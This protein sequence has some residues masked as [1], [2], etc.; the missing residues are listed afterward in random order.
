VLTR[1]PD[2][3]LAVPAEDLPWRNSNFITGVESMPVCFTPTEKVGV[4]A[5]TE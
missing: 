3:E 5:A 1:L 2:I 4:A